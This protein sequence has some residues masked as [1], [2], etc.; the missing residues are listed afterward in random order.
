M[1][2]FYI[3]FTCEYTHGVSAVPPDSPVHTQELNGVETNS[4]FLELVAKQLNIFGFNR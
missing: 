3:I 2:L 4:I 1:S